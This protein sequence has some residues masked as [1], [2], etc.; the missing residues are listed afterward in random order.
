MAH[1][2]HA[3]DHVFVHEILIA[4]IHRP[5][6]SVKL[7]AAADAVLKK[8]NVS[9]IFFFTTLNRILVSGTI[10]REVN[11]GSKFDRE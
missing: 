8:E 7:G 11:V 4:S 10:T 2:S 3:T 5:L 9:Q 6:N 1:I